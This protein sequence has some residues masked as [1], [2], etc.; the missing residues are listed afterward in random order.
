[1]LSNGFD[2]LRNIGK[3]FIKNINDLAFSYYREKKFSVIK[4]SKRLL[5]E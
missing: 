1:V 2:G 3:K 5:K 4:K